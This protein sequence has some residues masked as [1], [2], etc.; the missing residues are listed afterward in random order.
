MQVACQVAAHERTPGFPPVA[1]FRVIREGA[2]GSIPRSFKL[3]NL[4]FG[5]FIGLAP[6]ANGGYINVMFR[7][8][9]P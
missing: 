4:W 8:P 7:D 6:L 3:H 1:R 2:A 9:V 5:R